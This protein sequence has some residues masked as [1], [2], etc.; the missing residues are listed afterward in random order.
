MAGAVAKVTNVLAIVPIGGE[1]VFNGLSRYIRI[2]VPRLVVMARISAL[3]LTPLM[4][5][6]HYLTP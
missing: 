4:R 2:F 5:Y 1:Y 3:L 6:L